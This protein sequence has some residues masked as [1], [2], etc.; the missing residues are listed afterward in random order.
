MHVGKKL[1]TAIQF[2]KA[3]RLRE[4]EGIYREILQLEPSNPD[5]LH[6]LGVIATQ[7]GRLDRAIDLL[8]QAVTIRPA[9]ATYHASLGTALA[10]CGD[11]RAAAASLLRA[12]E[13]DPDFA[14]AQESLVAVYRAQ[15]E[16]KS[17]I[18]ASGTAAFEHGQLV[19]GIGTG[20]SGSTTLVKILQSQPGAFAS[21][22]RPPRLAWEGATRR[23]KVHMDCFEQLMRR[24]ALVADVAHWWLPYLREVF[25]AFP[26]LK[27]I[28][29]RR[30]RESTVRSF[31]RIKG[32]P[33][34][35]INHWSDHKGVD[36]RP[37]VWDEC[38]PTYEIMDRREAIGRYWDQYYGQVEMWQKE[39]PGQVFL[40][41]VETLNL[42][43][44]QEALFDF[45]GLDKRVLVPAH[46]YN[47]GTVADGAR[48][49]G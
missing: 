18:P 19:I 26:T 44:G 35:A 14:P 32:F 42:Q 9:S 7:V 29:L 41:Q 49:W 48:L 39:R 45:L 2:H 25:D 31:E 27:V 16:T 34:G 6:L 21:H 4:A 11:T 40:A 30:D 23:L 36:W 13:I 10:H 12:L 43:K 38:Y 17:R 33:P 1:E 3:G 22:E 47:A 46:K 37:N 24:Y 28:A 8:R 20:R 15:G 5:A